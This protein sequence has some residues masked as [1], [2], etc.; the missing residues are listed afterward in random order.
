MLRGSF[1]PSQS[2]CQDS[3]DNAD[4]AKKIGEIGAEATQAEAGETHHRKLL[5]YALQL[6]YVECMSLPSGSGMLTKGQFHV[7]THTRQS[8][9]PVPRMSCC[10]SRYSTAQPIGDYVQYPKVHAAKYL[11]HSPFRIAGW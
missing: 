3:D 7:C 5:D 4:E 10:S 9:C 6:M 1:S 11:P 2:L 8:C